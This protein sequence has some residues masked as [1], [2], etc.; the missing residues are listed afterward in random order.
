MFR[1]AT[2]S[3]KTL[4]QITQTLA[5]IVHQATVARPGGHF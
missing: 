5:D 4:A 3:R 1:E 2:G